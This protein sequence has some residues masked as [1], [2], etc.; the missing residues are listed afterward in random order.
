MRWKSRENFSEK[1]G[2][3]N[4]ALFTAGNFSWNFFELMNT[5]FVTGREIFLTLSVQH[6]AIFLYI[7]FSTVVHME[8][9]LPQLESLRVAK[10]L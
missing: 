4:K 3:I 9:T 5:G 7:N 8:G 2:G 6:E 10:G 1:N